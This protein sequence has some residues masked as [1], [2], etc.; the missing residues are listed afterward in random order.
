MNLSVQIEGLDRIGNATQAVRDSVAREIQVALKASGERV[1]GEAIKSILEGNK[2]GK[3]YRRGS[4]THKASA[5]GEAPANDTGRLASSIIS[6]QNK[7]ESL[8]IAGRGQVKYAAFLEFGTERM[9]ERP[10]MLP[11]LEKSRNW[12]KERLNKAVRDGAVKAGKK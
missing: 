4:V 11:A 3:I 5:P 8:V 12:I 6:I 2:S 10:F 1:R 9:A 7:D